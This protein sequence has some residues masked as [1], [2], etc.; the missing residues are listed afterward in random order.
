MTEKL[1]P[2]QRAREAAADRLALQGLGRP[3]TD[4]AN[5]LA[6]AVRKGQND[7]HP[8]V[9]AFARFEQLILARPGNAE[10]EGLRYHA[11]CEISDA[12]MLA[13]RVLK[14]TK[15]DRDA[16][17]K[18]SRHMKF[19]YVPARM[20]SGGYDLD[21]LVLLFANHRPATAV[22]GEVREA[23]ARI[24]DSDGWEMRGIWLD[25]AN[26]PKNDE[27]LVRAYRHDAEA[28][29]SNSLAKA[30]AILALISSDLIVDRGAVI[31]ECA[32]VAESHSDDRPRREGIDWNDGYQD[33]CR[34]AAA[35]IR[36][37]G[38]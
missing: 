22:A 26:D 34:G 19:A 1:I 37:R 33:G 11:D 2:S 35:A 23:V 25:H 12:E 9:I 7:D 29:V 38:A 3:Y 4:S 5:R 21:P 27:R 36:A 32:R 16:A 14:P 28:C 13:A 17:M 8:W 24:I 15:A 18:A 31:E 20:E 10:V 6:D 30:D